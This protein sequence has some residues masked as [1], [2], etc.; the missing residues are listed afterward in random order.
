MVPFELLFVIL[1]ANLRMA[2][3]FV[4]FA[5]LLA[6]AAGVVD[7]GKD[8]V[9][10]TFGRTLYSDKDCTDALWTDASKVWCESTISSSCAF[11]KTDPTV[12]CEG[13]SAG[14]VCSWYVE[15]ECKESATCTCD[16][17]NPGDT[18]KCSPV[19]IYDGS[20]TIYGTEAP[21]GT[22]EKGSLSGA[23]L[24]ARNVLAALSTVLLSVIILI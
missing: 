8:A 3:R 9:K 19:G 23:S 20:K 13:E 5:L 7:A 15:R 17:F 21:K 18:S 11:A 16:G 22:C 12:K 14:N 6:S 4:G 2:R 1:F 24:L 10:M